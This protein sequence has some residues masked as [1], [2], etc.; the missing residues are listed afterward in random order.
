[1]N[2]EIRQ[3]DDEDNQ[4][5]S[6]LVHKLARVFSENNIDISMSLH[7]SIKL[8]INQACYA[9]MVV[10]ENAPEGL[11][12]FIESLS[13][14]LNSITKESI[15]NSIKDFKKRKQNLL[16]KNS[17]KIMS[18]SNEITKIF[19]KDSLPLEDSLKACVQ[20]IINIKAAKELQTNEIEKLQKKNDVILND[21][22]QNITDL[23]SHSFSERIK[24][25]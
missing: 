15:P 11:D 16:R 6:I 9:Y 4:K 2:L 7:A 5:A 19:I 21:L 18:T 25:R 22:M 10:E 24:D 12:E 3:S 14:T 20:T 13:E 17:D 23:I 8:V 1:M